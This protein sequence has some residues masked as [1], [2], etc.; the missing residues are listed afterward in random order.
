[1]RLFYCLE[2]LCMCSYSDVARPVLP[3][4]CVFIHVHVYMYYT[5]MHAHMECELEYV[6]I[7]GTLQSIHLLWY[8]YCVCVY[9]LKSQGLFFGLLCVPTQLLFLPVFQ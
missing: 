3:S 6:T 1:M 9:L 5:C 2:Y 4:T 8:M 7:L